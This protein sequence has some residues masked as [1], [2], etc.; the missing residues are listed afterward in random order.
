MQGVDMD[1]DLRMNMYLRVAYLFV[2]RQGTIRH[3]DAQTLSRHSDT[4]TALSVR[5]SECLIVTF[6]ECLRV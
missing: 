5:A 3:A 2:A 6:L 1:I 4:N